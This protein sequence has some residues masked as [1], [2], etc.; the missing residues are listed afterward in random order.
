MWH[1]KLKALTLIEL[2]VAIGI[3]ALLIVA[4][5]PYFGGSSKKDDMSSKGNQVSTFILRARNFA[6]N[7]DIDG[8]NAKQY[9]VQSTAENSIKIVRIDLNSITPVD[10]GGESLQLPDGYK[11]SLPSDIVFDSPTGA[12]SGSSSVVVRVT[13]AK[14]SSPSAVITI[15]KPGVADVALQ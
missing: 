9:I 11:V 4:A 2:L 6:L 8:K 10:L 13:K 3:S 15:K 5:I 7:P 12:L 14:Q 1:A